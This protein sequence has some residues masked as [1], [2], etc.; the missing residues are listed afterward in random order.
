[1]SLEE[2][3]HVIKSCMSENGL[4]FTDS[5]LD[6]LTQTFFNEADLDGSGEL[7]FDEFVDLLDKSPGILETMVSHDFNIPEN[8]KPADRNICFG[9]KLT[10][11][12]VKNNLVSYAF[13]LTFLVINGALIAGRFYTYREYSYYA[14]IAKSCGQCLNFTCSFTLFLMLRKS[15]TKL[16]SWGCSQYLPLDQSIYY[17]KVIGYFITFYAIFHATF[18]CFYFSKLIIKCLSMY[19]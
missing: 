19:P 14:R 8:G 12:Y 11:S 10:L 4:S 15:I 9:R 7:S 18:H 2:L 1:M 5:D 13:F 16:R 17:H 6:L 3:R